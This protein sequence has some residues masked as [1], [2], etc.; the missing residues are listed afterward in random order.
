VLN[1]GKLK[2][3]LWALALLPMA[4]VPVL[5]PILLFIGDAFFDR[6]LLQKVE[7]DLAVANSHLQHLQT[8]ISAATLSVAKSRRIKEF[9]H[10]PGG[11]LSEVLASR[12]E[13]LDF[14]LLAVVDA[15]GNVIGSSDEVVPGGSYIQLGVLREAIQSGKEVSGLEVVPREHLMKLHASLADKALVKLVD[16]PMAA[17]KAAREDGRALM[18]LAAA[19]MVDAGGQVMAYVLGG[20]LLNHRTDYVDYVREIVSGGGLRQMGVEGTVTLFLDDVRIETTVRDDKGERA[21]GTRVSQTV[22]ES[23]LD[24]GETW[25]QRAFVV[26]HWAVTAYRPLLDYRGERVG[27]T[28]VGIPEGPFTAFRWQALGLAALLIVLSAGFAAW[29][30]L[31]LAGSILRPM[32]RLETA[33]RAVGKGDMSARVGAMPG[34]NELVR[35]GR[36]F[37]RLLGTIDRQTGDLRR[38]GSELDQKV[39]RRTEELAKAN[40]ALVIARDEADRANQAKSAFLANMSHEI[41]TPMNAILGLTHLLGKELHAAHQRE[42]LGKIS[43]AALHLLAVI[44]DILDVS[45]IDAGKLQLENAP[46]SIERVFDSVC[47]MAAERSYAKG[48]ELVRDMAPELSATFE[49]DALRLGQILLNYVGNAIKFTE[50]G[51]IVLRAY[52]VRDSGAR[53]LVRFEVRDTGIGI[54]PEVIPRLFSAFEQ[55]DSSTTRKYGGTGLGLT[56]SRRL[57][58]MMGGEVGVESEPG[59]GST[60]WFTAWLGCSGE[61]EVLRPGLA[62]L[63]NW[64]VLVVDDCQEARQVLVDMLAQQGLRP[65]DADCGETALGM[66]ERADGLGDP[67][68]IVLLDW[69]MPGLDGMQT[70]ALLSSMALRYRPH[71][72]LVTAYDSELSSDLCRSTGFDIMLAKPVS[73]S[74]LSDAML[75]LVGRQA[76]PANLDVT[77]LDRR[78]IDEHGGQRVLLAEDNEINREVATELL[79]SAGLLVDTAE[80]G[81]QALAQLRANRYELILMD[82]QMPVMD[83]LEATRRIRAMPGYG[84]LPILA[85]TANAFDDDVSECVAAGMNAHVAKPVDPDVLFQA[86]LDWLPKR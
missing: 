48:V 11:V 80:D 27:M 84:D 17:S 62:S 4:S 78:L 72:M 43:D 31:R 71:Y 81:E 12:E 7:N 39:E 20:V 85:L 40:E 10:Q 47:S 35:L 75:A 51:V 37:D 83:G 16:T 69:R 73:P 52:V 44:N 56:I 41:R 67:Y 28:Y 21:I 68:R 29:V 2:F 33:M 8:E 30:S 42:R 65:D 45:K 70:A 34:D 23:V 32:E 1:P 26:N 25:L 64:R 53:K 55:A 3:R 57:A 36:L 22:K 59:R 54:S 50:S 74:T 76:L 13:N 86:L 66:V 60:F 5:L 77:E 82:V 49:G 63:N 19:P 24:R 38:W 9:T 14:D 79:T 18:I 46:F 61:T 15:E 6:L 58:E